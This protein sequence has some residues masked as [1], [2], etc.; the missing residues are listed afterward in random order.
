MFF[1]FLFSF[2]K[3]KN[4]SFK[5]CAKREIV[6]KLPHGGRNFRISVQFSRKKLKGNFFYIKFFFN[7]LIENFL[8]IYY[9]NRNIITFANF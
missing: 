6:L 4:I 8:E 5:V 7:N 9:S 3:K 1:F 2:K